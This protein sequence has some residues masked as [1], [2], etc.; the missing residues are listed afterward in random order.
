MYLRSNNQL[1]QFHDVFIG[2]IKSVFGEPVV[3]TTKD[4]NHTVP[5][6]DTNSE[7]LCFTY[8]NIKFS[9]M[10]N[11]H[12]K[13]SELL[14]EIYVTH[15]PEYYF[16]LKEGATHG[17]LTSDRKKVISKRASRQ[18]KPYFLRVELQKISD[19]EM[20][21][22]V[23]SQL[24]IDARDSEQKIDLQKEIVHALNNAYQNTSRSK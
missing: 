5:G 13:D 10:S 4:K 12:S 19:N 2:K 14:I 11:A 1:T 24:R 21:W 7:I 3:R 6:F 20:E 22:F 9:I 15:H 16:L 18:N 17:L 23:E 8:K